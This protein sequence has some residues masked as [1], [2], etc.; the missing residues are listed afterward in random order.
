MLKFVFLVKRA[1]H[2]THDELVRHWQEIHLPGVAEHLR[3]DHY[4]VTFFDQR[5]EAP[6]DGMAVLWYADAERGRYM[7]GEGSPEAVRRDGF[8]DRVQTPYT[9]LE[10]EEHVIVD[11]PR[12]GEALKLTALVRAKAGIDGQELYQ[13]WLD[14]HAPNVAGELRSTAGGLRYALSFATQGQSEP[15]FAGMAELWY[16][17][18]DASRAHAEKLE[19]DGFGRYVEAATMLIGREIVGIP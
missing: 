19:D 10:C 11:G 18:A 17:S 8:L 5:D 16:E 2:V 13:H 4:R 1:D 12:P 6:F 9:K 3:P 7:L 14:V 15:D